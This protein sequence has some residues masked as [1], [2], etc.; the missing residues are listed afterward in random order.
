MRSV[1]ASK[2]TG[3]Y[4]GF[5]YSALFS[6]LGLLIESLFFIYYG[7]IILLTDIVHWAVDTLVEVFGLIALYYAVRFGRRFPWSILVLES[8]AMLLSI[9][10]ALGIYIFFFGSYITSEFAMGEPTT[11]SP[12]PA[13]ATTI[14]GL[15]TGLTLVIQVK[16][17]RLYELEVLRVDYTHALIDL[18]AAFSATI[19]ILLVY[20]TRSQSLELLFTLITTMFIVHSL[21]EI[22]RDIVKTITGSNIDYELSNRLLKKLVNELKGVYIED[23]IARKIGSFY[24]VEARIGVDPYEKLVAIHKLR[25]RIVNTVINESDLIYHV[26]VKFYPLKTKYRRRK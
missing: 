23:I 6:L 13:L 12:I 19:G 7:G 15:L 26:D 20:T 21:L 11:R 24:I 1:I 16:N 9:I 17:Y 8:A 10:M 3:A 5:V 4:R 18:I 14:G 22:L 25:N 2:L